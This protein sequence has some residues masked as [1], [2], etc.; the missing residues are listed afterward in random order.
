MNHIKLFEEDLN[1]FTKDLFGFTTTLYLS[2]IANKIGKELG[3]KDQE[4]IL[5]SIKKHLETIGIKSKISEKPMHIEN[6]YRPVLIMAYTDI[7]VQDLKKYFPDKN[8]FS[9]KLDFY[10][11]NLEYPRDALKVYW[12]PIKGILV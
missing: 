4:R 12:H 5:D 6:F 7:K 11:K 2:G 10:L 8:N 3:R 9:F 1:D